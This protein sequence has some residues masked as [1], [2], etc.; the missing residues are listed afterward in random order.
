MI[1][2]H[3]PKQPKKAMTNMTLK[4]CQGRRGR[5]NATVKRRRKGGGIRDSAKIYTH[6]WGLRKE[7]FALPSDEK[8]K[9]KFGR[10]R[11]R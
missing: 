3:H 5:V 7:H 2:H 10:K 11:K 1:S 6:H 9:K 4:Y 8:K